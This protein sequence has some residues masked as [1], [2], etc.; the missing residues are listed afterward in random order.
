MKRLLCVV[1]L[2]VFLNFTDRPFAEDLSP[3]ETSVADEK[4]L[5]DL[6]TAR[7][8]WLESVSLYGHYSFREVLFFLPMKLK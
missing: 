2:V 5:D 1:F 4:L 7:K 3:A 8:T 6:E